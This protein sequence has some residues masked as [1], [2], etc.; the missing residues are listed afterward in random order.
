MLINLKYLYFYTRADA[1]NHLLWL[2]LV[3]TGLSVAPFD[4]FNLPS[5]DH[6][7]DSVLVYFLTC[8]A[9]LTHLHYGYGVVR[10]FPHA[11]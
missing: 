11:Y 1:W 10:A 2:V 8:I 3:V 4:K 9:T 7:I 5:F 6:N